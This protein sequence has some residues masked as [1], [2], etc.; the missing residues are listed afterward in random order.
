MHNSPEYIPFD[1]ADVAILFV[2]F[3]IFDSVFTVSKN[4]TKQNMIMDC[5]KI[6]NHQSLPLILGDECV[7]D[8]RVFINLRTGLREMV[9]NL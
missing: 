5:Q 1:D 6:S 2:D 7:V 3:S 4:K 9:E 8:D